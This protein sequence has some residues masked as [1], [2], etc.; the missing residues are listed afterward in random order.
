MNG[1]LPFEDIWIGSLLARF[2]P[3]NM[4]AIHIGTHGL[5]E[6]LANNETL[7]QYSDDHPY[8]LRPSSI[9]W[10][11]VGFGGKHKQPWRLWAVHQ[12]AA[13][14]ACA[15]PEISSVRLKCLARPYRSC[16]NSS[17]LQCHY[18]PPEG[19]STWPVACDVS[20]HRELLGC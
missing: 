11:E 19:C 18:L 14:H 7:D 20:P 2:A 1:K 4:T 12:W 15:P 10:H 8:D 6:S 16:A 13:A 5:G 3:H 17:W 9:V